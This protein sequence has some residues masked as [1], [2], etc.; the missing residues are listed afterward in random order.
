MTADEA[1]TR[2]SLSR[3][4]PIAA[5]L[6]L[7]ALPERVW[8]D[9]EWERIRQGHRSAAAADKW[10]VFVEGTRLYAQRSW[11]GRG[12]YEA[13]FGRAP[14]GGWRITEAVVESD[15]EAHDRTTE[16]RDCAM[17]QI[18]VSGVVLGVRD[19]GLWAR[20]REAVPVY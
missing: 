3:C 9:A 1:V 17:L 15:Q 2:A 4:E 10:D 12:V 6:P 11:A 18:I 20:W 14:G 19:P 7:T 16:A 5:P 8:T 13:E